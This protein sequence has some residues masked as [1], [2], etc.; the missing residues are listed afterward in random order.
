MTIDRPAFVGLKDSK[1]ASAIP[2]PRR[3]ACQEERFGGV[4]RNEG[5]LGD[6]WHPYRREGRDQTPCLHLEIEHG[7]GRTP[8]PRPSETT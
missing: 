6:A 5:D 4:K 8:I 7:S 3:R 2:L 1:R